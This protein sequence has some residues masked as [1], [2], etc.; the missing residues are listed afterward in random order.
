MPAGNTLGTASPLNFRVSNLQVVG[1]TVSAS[2]PDYYIFRL[3]G[4]SSLDFT[5][6]S[7]T[8]GSNVDF[9][10]LA[11][12]GTVVQDSRN[13]GNLADSINRFDQAA[14]VYYLQVYTDSPTNASY[15]LNLINRNTART[16]I[17]WRNYG[18]P[19]LSGST[20]LWT[21]NGLT[22]VSTVNFPVSPSPDWQIAGIGDFNQDGQADIVWRNYGA[23]VPPGGRTVIW[24]IDLLQI[25]GRERS[26]RAKNEETSGHH[27]Q[28][29]S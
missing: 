6:N 21:M 25:S 18:T 3:N 20:A 14:G 7:L 23:A 24:T 28:N 15:S 26:R 9:K 12:N 22:P 27:N 19:G 13:S 1:D 2:A 29:S 17:I 16:D 5:L 4:R 10:L 11:S 8:L